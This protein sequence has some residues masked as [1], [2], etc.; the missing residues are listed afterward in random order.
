MI[1]FRASTPT[2]KFPLY[3]NR[4]LK[5]INLH[6]MNNAHG[7]HSS[8]TKPVVCDGIIKSRGYCSFN[9]LDNL[10]AVSRM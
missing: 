1:F 3:G 8:S 2:L 6:K 4:Y 9:I 5:D 7:L 10:Y